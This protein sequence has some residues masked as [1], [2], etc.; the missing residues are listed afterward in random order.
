VGNGGHAAR[1]K[2]IGPFSESI[3]ETAIAEA[4]HIESRPNF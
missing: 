2:N 3:E 4:A 1:S